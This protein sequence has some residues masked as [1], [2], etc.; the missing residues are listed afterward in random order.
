[1]MK[2][3]K[4]DTSVTLKH[5]LKNNLWRHDEATLVPKLSILVSYVK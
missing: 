2:R 1:M 3:K 5:K 4:R